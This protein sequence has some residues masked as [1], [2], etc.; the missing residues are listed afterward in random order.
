MLAIQFNL[1]DK[2]GEVMLNV[3]RC[4]V[5]DAVKLRL[6]NRRPLGELGKDIADPIVGRI[7]ALDADC[8]TAIGR[9][10]GL[11]QAVVHLL[12][13]V[14][15]VHPKI[16][17]KFATELGHPLHGEVVDGG[18]HALDAIAGT[19]ELD[20]QKIGV[21]QRVR[22]YDIYPI[23]IACK[24]HLVDFTIDNGG[25]AVALIGLDT[26]AFLELLVLDFG[27]LAL[28]LQI[29]LGLFIVG[30][31]VVLEPISQEATDGTDKTTDCSHY[32][33]NTCFHFE[34]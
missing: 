2:F 1:V 34:N 17:G 12:V 29:E 26:G 6:V 8:H 32:F 18:A 21:L 5:H 23:G 30:I 20:A 16:L 3:D 11:G 28:H 25:I 4:I 9:K 27:L 7:E 14:V 15:E 33:C 24:E 22:L 10:Q 19:L 31:L 13:D